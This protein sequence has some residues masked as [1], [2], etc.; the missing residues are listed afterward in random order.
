MAILN[1]LVINQLLGLIGGRGEKREEGSKCIALIIMFLRITGTLEAG[2]VYLGKVASLIELH[3][4]LID[5]QCSHSLSLICKSDM[6]LQFCS[7]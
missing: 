2:I 3:F 1:I 5:R 4:Y 6:R 7:F